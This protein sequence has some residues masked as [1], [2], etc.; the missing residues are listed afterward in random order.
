MKAKTIIPL[1]LR[2]M[3]IPAVDWSEVDCS[4]DRQPPRYPA[5][6]REGKSATFYGLRAAIFYGLDPR[7]AWDAHEHDFGLP[8]QKVG[9]EL[10]REEVE[11]VTETFRV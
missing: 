8:W 9:P 6:L 3:G 1:D 11:A 10:T 4:T 5:E 7:K 2:A